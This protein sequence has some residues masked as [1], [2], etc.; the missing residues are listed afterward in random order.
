MSNQIHSVIF[1]VDANAEIGFGHIMRMRS[2]AGECIA[3]GWQTVFC[4]DVPENLA[5]ILV[6]EGH[7]MLP[8][9]TT[10]DSAAVEIGLLEA[11]KAIGKR[12]WVVLDGYGF[13]GA[14]QRRLLNVGVRLMVMDDYNHLS[15][16]AAHLIVNQNAGAE[17]SR[18]V[19]AQ[20]SVCL[21]GS[22]YA[23]LRKEFVRW[24]SWKREC[25]AAGR[26]VLLTVGGSDQKGI[27]LE[28]LLALDCGYGEKL[29]IHL[30]AGAENPRK[31]ELEALAL[32]TRHQVRIS[33]YTEN[34]AELMAWA[35]IALTAGGSTLWESA[36]MS[37]PSVV[38][39]IA[40]NQR[41]GAEAVAAA[42]AAVYIGEFGTVASD[43][44]A[45]AVFQLSSDRAGRLGMG[46][47]GRK[48]VDG[49]GAE[50]VRL[51]M[52]NLAE[53]ANNIKTYEH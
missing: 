45:E 39:S 50:R 43:L 34:M 10:K 2:L 22:R 47:A 20:D 15:D 5:S 14:Y 38:V 8:I 28:W 6:A 40:D 37:L 13:D 49:R 12:P 16:Y 52:E 23:L 42:G 30:L 11:V 51:T 9:G 17:R 46:F 24:G 3:N 32:R 36:F 7:Q 48:L 41:S 21:L 31:K 26:R 29:N 19:L 25:P 18:Y 35:D 27:S 53:N 4:G 44:V 1:R 33:Q